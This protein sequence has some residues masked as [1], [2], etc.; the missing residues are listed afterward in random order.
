ML[1][2]G[3]SNQGCRGLREGKQLGMGERSNQLPSLRKACRSGMNN[4][5]RAHDLRQPMSTS[6]NEDQGLEVMS[7]QE[8]PKIENDVS[9][10]KNQYKLVQEK[11]SRI[12]DKIATLKG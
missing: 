5:C 1:G 6:K 7:S 2:N 10:L 12:A 9:K 11:L 4:R 3:Q 8:Q